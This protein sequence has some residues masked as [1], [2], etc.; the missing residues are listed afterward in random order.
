MLIKNAILNLAVYQ[1]TRNFRNLPD[2][3]LQP[4]M[5]TI[6]WLIEYQSFYKSDG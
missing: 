3:S 2:S 1:H 5:N 4:T 6:I